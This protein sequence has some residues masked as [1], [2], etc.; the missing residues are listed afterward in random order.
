MCVVLCCVVLYDIITF[1]VKIL[2]SCVIMCYVE[3]LCVCHTN[4]MCGVTLMMSTVS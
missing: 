1:Y 4:M 3:I 2:C